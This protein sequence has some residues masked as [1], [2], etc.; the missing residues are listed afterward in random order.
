MPEQ[1]VRIIHGVSVYL[2]DEC[3]FVTLDYLDHAP[4]PGEEIEVDGERWVV[5]EWTGVIEC[6]RLTLSQHD[7]R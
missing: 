3:R 4:R 2:R 7:S 1:K 5:A 6:E